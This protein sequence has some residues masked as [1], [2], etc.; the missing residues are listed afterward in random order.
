MAPELIL[1]ILTADEKLP[2]H[3]TKESD[4]YAFAMVTIEV[5][6]TPAEIG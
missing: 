2:K 1:P 5:L 3:S 6:H 4:V